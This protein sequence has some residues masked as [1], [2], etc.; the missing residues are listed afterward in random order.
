MHRRK[1]HIRFVLLFLML[2][3]HSTPYRLV[4]VDRNEPLAQISGAVLK[5]AYSKLG[6]EFVI[7]ETPVLRTFFSL[8]ESDIDG[9]LYGGDWM[10]SSSIIKLDTPVGYDEDVVFSKRQDIEAGNWDSLKPYRIGV[11]SKY[12]E[13]ATHLK[14]MKL[15]YVDTQDQ[16]FLMLNADR[17]DVVITSYLMGLYTLDKLQIN[18]I[19]TTAKPLVTRSLF[20]FLTNRHR[21]LALKL[22]KVLREMEYSGELERIAMDKKNEIIRSLSAGE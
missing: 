10:I 16:L 4:A 3:L 9:L 2:N 17:T 1:R 8:G 19:R 12:P 5:A 11:I 7:V 20:H 22:N 14:G 18:T 15:D 21:A 13:S 6:E